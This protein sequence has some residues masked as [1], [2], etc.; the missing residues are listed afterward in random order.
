MDAPGGGQPS[1]FSSWGVPGDLSL[2]PE[3]TAPGG[4]IYSV[5]AAYNSS[6]GVQ[7]ADHRQY[8]NMSG[9]SMAAPQIPGL[10][11]VIGEYYRANDVKAK[12]GLTLRQFAQ[13]LLMST[14]TPMKPEGQYLSVLQKGAGLAEVNKAINASSVLM[15]N[16][17]GLTSA[18]GA[19]ADG[20]VKVELGDDPDREGSYEYSL[21]R[22]SVV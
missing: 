10:T 19:N 11:A 2:K 6:S 5:K 4:N 20:K 7:A 1:D 22:E 12:T 15:M 14:A 16:E 18:T 21:D 13:S 3:I 8:E 17:A 9:T